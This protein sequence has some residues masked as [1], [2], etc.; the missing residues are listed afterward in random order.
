MEEEKEIIEA[1][2]A[3]E[4]IAES[5]VLHY[6][7]RK[8]EYYEAERYIREDIPSPSNLGHGSGIASPTEMKF[9]KLS[10]LDEA[11]SWLLV[12]ELMERLLSPKQVLFLELRRRA[13]TRSETLQSIGK[14]KI[15]W[16]VFVQK[17]FAEQMAKKYKRPENEFWLS[18]QTLYTWWK[19]IVTVTLRIAYHKKCKF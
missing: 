4:S 14:G 11:E 18:E 1:L 10:D 13:A 15:N 19:R 3:D 8:N 6:Q 2:K 5:W 7:K 17:K 12:V 16:V 9:I